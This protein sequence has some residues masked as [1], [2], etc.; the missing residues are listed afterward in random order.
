MCMGVGWVGGTAVTAFSDQLKLELTRYAW[1][2]MLMKNANIG[3]W[4]WSPTLPLPQN[5]CFAHWNSI[6]DV[7]RP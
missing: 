3:Y 7:F 2:G 6:A 5:P 4:K 1:L